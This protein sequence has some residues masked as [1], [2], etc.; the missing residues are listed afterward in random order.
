MFPGKCFKEGRIDQNGH[1]AIKETGLVLEFPGIY[2]GFSSQRCIGHSDQAGGYV[3]IPDSALK[4]G[5]RKTAQV[6]GHPAAQVDQKAVPFSTGRHE[7][8]PQ[9]ACLVQGFRLFTPGEHL[10]Q[11][12]TGQCGAG[13]QQDGQAIPFRIPV[14]QDED[15]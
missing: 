9:P 10:Q 2:C 5:C 11:A 7:L 13:S 12:G 1:R 15:A 6:A 14:G 3:Y 4:T 8:F